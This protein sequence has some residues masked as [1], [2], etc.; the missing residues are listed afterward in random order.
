ML[1]MRLDA[2]A[3]V[4]HRHFDIFQRRRARKQV[5]TLK[6]EADFFVADIR[7][8]IAVERGNVNAIQQIMTAAGTVQRADHVHQRAFAGAA[9]THDGH[10]F[11]RKNL[12]RNPAHRMNVHFTGV[13][14]LVDV[15]KLD[16]GI[17]LHGNGDQRILGNRQAGS[18]SRGPRAG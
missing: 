2:V 7:E 9:R 18:G 10:K 15:R 14:H 12:Q 1:F 6:D 17:G 3:V 5:E 16:D 4:K 8:G 11:A 13:I